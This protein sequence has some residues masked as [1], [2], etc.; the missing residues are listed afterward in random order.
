MLMNGMCIIEFHIEIRGNVKRFIKILC[1]ICIPLSI[2]ATPVTLTCD[3]VT[4][5]VDGSVCIDLVGYRWYVAPIINTTGSFTLVSS[6]ISN[7]TTVDL[8]NG[9]W[10]LCVTAVAPGA[11]SD[12]SSNI[13]HRIGKP[14]N[15][16]KFYVK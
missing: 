6:T 11:E 5:N 8:P 1:L 13:V 3:P 4:K 15:P 7:I 2:L 10:L 9:L 12:P 14:H 16:T